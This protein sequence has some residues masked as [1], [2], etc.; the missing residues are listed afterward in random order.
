MID[1]VGARDLGSTVLLLEEMGKT[2]IR[3]GLTLRQGCHAL[4][5]RA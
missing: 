2:Q 1:E 5:L 3:V 4:R